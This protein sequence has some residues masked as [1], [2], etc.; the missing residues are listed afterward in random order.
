MLSTTQMIRRLE[1]MVGTSDL[2]SWETDFVRSLVDRL[3]RLHDKHF[4]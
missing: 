3:E 2:S 1:G 4:A